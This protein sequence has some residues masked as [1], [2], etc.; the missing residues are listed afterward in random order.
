MI[1]MI[2]DDKNCYLPNNPRLPPPL[3]VGSVVPLCGLQ[4]LEERFGFNTSH[5]SKNS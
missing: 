4:T 1:M 2:N 3:A 5:W